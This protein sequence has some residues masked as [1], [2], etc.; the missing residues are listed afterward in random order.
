MAVRVA[1]LEARIEELTMIQNLLLRLLSTTRPLAR[2]LEHYGATETQEKAFYRLLD[3][4]AERARGPE[5]DHPSFAF[6]QRGV[7]EIF[8]DRR[9][10]AEF[11]QMLMDTLKVERAAYRDLHA[12]MFERGWQAP[13]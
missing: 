13:E 1:Q 4:L 7:N 3:G 5:R 10:D 9:D 11:L 6:F 2:V 12:Y 8:H